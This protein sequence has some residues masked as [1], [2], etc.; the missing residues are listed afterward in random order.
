MSEPIRTGAPEI[1]YLSL[2]ECAEDT[3]YIIGFLNHFGN[4]VAKSES[5]FSI[6]DAYRKGKICIHVHFTPRNGGMDG[7]QCCAVLKRLSF[8]T[9][10]VARQPD[11]ALFMGEN[12]RKDDP[13]FVHYVKLMDKPQR[14]YF[15]SILSRVERLQFLKFCNYREFHTV[16]LASSIPS[17]S[18]AVLENRE[19]G[20]S[21]GLILTNQNQ[22]ARQ[23]VE[24][25]TQLMNELSK[26]NSNSDNIKF[27]VEIDPLVMFGSVG[28]FIG[29]DLM[30]LGL[31]KGSN[32]FF[33]S[34]RLLF[35]AC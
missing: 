29:H 25:T 10:A 16:H 4:E 3:G 5:G 26:Q 9:S 35:S 21:G 12:H 31:R 23:I 28:V 13:V 24:C 20:E 2:E 30:G 19:L 8:D 6:L 33:D 17:E 15:G 11:L 14:C 7:Q 27:G 34:Y 32:S 22:L 18:A 1:K